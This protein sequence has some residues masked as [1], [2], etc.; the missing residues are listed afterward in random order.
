VLLASVAL[1]LMTGPLAS[2]AH[3]QESGG[4]VAGMGANGQGELGVGFQDKKELVPTTA[5]HLSGVT[6]IAQGFNFT[7]A[8]LPN[9]T[10]ESWGVNN[11]GQL[12]TG[13]VDD[14]G[15][16]LSPQLIPGLQ[17]VTDIAA[18]GVHAIAVTES[19]QVYTWGRTEAGESGLAAQPPEEEGEGGGA[20]EPSE[21][22][23]AGV[24]ASGCEPHEP[25]SGTSAFG[26]PVEVPSLKPSELGGEVRVI[27][28]AAG[29]K[30]DYGRLSNGEVYAWGS[31]QHGQL[32]RPTPGKGIQI[33]KEE[34]TEESNCEL[35]TPRPT[36]KEQEEKPNALNE[37]HKERRAYYESHEALCPHVCMSEMGLVP[38][39]K[40]PHV[41]EAV[42]SVGGFKEGAEEGQHALRGVTS[43]ANCAET[44]YALV[45]G[46]VYAWGS[47]TNDELGTGSSE[48]S[49]PVPEL[50]KGLAGIIEVAG[51]NHQ[52]L[53]SNGSEVWAWGNGKNHDLGP[54]ASTGQHPEPV[55]VTE[56][57]AGKVERLGA[58][59]NVSFVIIGG[60]A[61]AFG[62]NSFG[63]A[64]VKTESEVKKPTAMV[65]V[66]DVEEAWGSEKRTEVLVGA[67]ADAPAP[68]LELTTAPESI[69]LSW[70][71]KPAGGYKVRQ[72]NETAKTPYSAFEY[73]AESA[74]EFSWPDAKEHFVPLAN[75]YYRVVITERS[76]RGETRVLWATL[77]PG[78]G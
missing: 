8:L 69:R 67:A 73:P 5:I 77:P 55:K 60:L 38:C 26:A 45:E 43:L 36:K 15:R 37:W 63:Q 49:N 65:G 76:G 44:A 28:V 19:G 20:E 74:S 39:R 18:S 50:V 48:R 14:P 75:G 52:A 46:H 42:T 61:Y 70:T 40:T 59:S 11:Y 4:V 7:L 21:E 57:P 35:T 3:A 6:K 25:R 68:L 13:T 71:Y 17:G 32:A 22:E 58:G 23:E 10:V 16:C 47:N 1:L 66:S 33:E 30:T 53:A 56:L 41:V 31:N 64:G 51:G 9:G 27:E 72:R 12:G 54:G 2:L 24:G 29:G 62:D 78:T 34:A